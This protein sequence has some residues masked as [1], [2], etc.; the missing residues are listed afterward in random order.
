MDERSIEGLL[1]AAAR[2]EERAFRPLFAETSPRLFA[3]CLRILQDRTEAEEALTDAFEKIWRHAGRHPATGTRPLTFMMA[4]TRDVCTARLHALGGRVTAFSTAAE[5]AAAAERTDRPAT[6]DDGRRLASCLAA[7]DPAEARL[8]SAA[9]FGAPG[10]SAV[11]HRE[12]A[13]GA[14]RADRAVAALADALLS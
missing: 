9:Y 14:A 12:G 11:A 10:R 6:D 4:I 2:G 13:A 5:V 7:L 1:A 3:L 8:V